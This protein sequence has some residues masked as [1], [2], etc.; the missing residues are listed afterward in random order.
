MNS[1]IKTYRRPEQDFFDARDPP[2]EMS[3]ERIVA[4]D[5][6]RTE[7]NWDSSEG[8]NSREKTGNKRKTRAGKKNSERKMGPLP[9]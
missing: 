1:R 7:F 9:G 3:P 6:T 8:A 2:F 5:E 4:D